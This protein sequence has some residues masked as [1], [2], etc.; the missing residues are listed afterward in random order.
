LAD[1]QTAPIDA[2][3][4][5]TLSFLHKLTLTPTELEPA[6]FERLRGHGLTDEAIAEVIEVAFLF[7]VIGRIADAFDFHLPTAD[8]LRWTVRILTRMGY[9]G[10]VL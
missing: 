9:G 4:R 8:N 2:K 1:W 10:V 3:L 7:N 6:D 5:D